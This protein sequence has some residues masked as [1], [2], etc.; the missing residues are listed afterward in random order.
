MNPWLFPVS[1]AISLFSVLSREAMEEFS[2]SD[3]EDLLRKR[4]KTRQLEERMEAFAH[5]LRHYV[6]AFRL[7]DYF[8]RSVVA[9]AV[10]VWA[11][12][13]ADGAAGW[14]TF[15]LIIA[16]FLF[17]AEIVVR[18]LG[19]AWSEPLALLLHRVWAGLVAV[20]WVPLWPFRICTRAMEHLVRGGEQETLEE[21]AEDEIMAAVSLGE[22]TGQIEEQ[23]RDMI[24]AVLNLGDLTVERL[25]TP[26]TEMNA[27]SLEL[28]T[29]GA[30]DLAKET[31]HSRLPVYEESRDNIRGVLYVKDLIGLDAEH[32]PS[33]EDLLRPPVFIP[34]SKNVA[35]L[36]TEFRR[37]R[38][39]L[40]IVLDEYGGTA[41]LITIEDIIEEVFGDI[42][43][44]YDEIGE[45]EV[46]T[47]ADSTYDLD[48]RMKVDEVNERFDCNLPES[49]RYESL[50][51]LL[52]AQLGH[53]PDTGSI[54]EV[55]GARL[56]VLEASDRRVRRVRLARIEEEPS[57]A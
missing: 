40:A 28:G 44:E 35:D 31:G 26:R 51:G 9:A 52:T 36:L 24:E 32:L 21:Q 38:V 25:M 33:L 10:F 42:D 29:A 56:T 53:I 37:N 48:A 47:L 22:A 45:A 12:A 5:H 15:A 8:A 57:N 19:A 11:F 2:F 23:E 43:D 54:W 55:D 7:I 20:L 18:P 27:C 49:E 13:I 41:G 4:G 46:R 1:V 6:F 16:A 17:L 39:H 30:L 34:A 14:L 3:A 50:G